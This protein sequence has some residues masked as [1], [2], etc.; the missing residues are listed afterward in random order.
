MTGACILYVLVYC[1]ALQAVIYALRSREEKKV[2]ANGSEEQEEEEVPWLAVWR[3]RYRSDGY[4]ALCGEGSSPTNVSHL[5]QPKRL[6][7][8][9]EA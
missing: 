3:C 1:L 7:M 4:K 5:K 2:G 8:T 6:N 9:C